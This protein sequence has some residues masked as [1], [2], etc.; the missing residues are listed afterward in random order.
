MA[1]TNQDQQNEHLPSHAVLENH[2]NRVSSSSMS[3]YSRL[4]SATHIG[5]GFIITAAHCLINRVCD[6]PAG[7]G[8]VQLASLNKLGIKYL[9]S[10]DGLTQTAFHDHTAI[11]AIVFHHGFL[12]LKRGYNQP[13]PQ[14]QYD[15]ALIKTNHLSFADAAE[16]PHP[17]ANNF[18]P[19]HISG[20]LYVF[21][22]GQESSEF[23]RHQMSLPG[24]PMQPLP[25]LSSPAQT[26][27]YGKVLATTLKLETL[28]KWRTHEL[29]QATPT[30][31]S[32]AKQHLQ[33]L[34]TSR[35][36]AFSC[37][38]EHA[39]PP[40]FQHTGD[41]FTYP[42]TLYRAINELDK[43]I[44][45]RNQDLLT[46]VSEYEITRLVREQ[47]LNNMIMATS[48]SDGT[49]HSGMIRGVCNGDSGGPLM[50]ESRNIIL[51]VVSFSLHDPVRKQA[52]AHGSRCGGYTFFPS[53]YHHLDWIHSAKTS[54]LAGNH[55]TN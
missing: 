45:Q 46:Q 51:G 50:D 39:Y 19:Q 36:T 22:A 54:V 10:A 1:T 28:I 17:S 11:E 12:G 40:K 7:D 41:G 8:V 53:I 33:P 44:G 30:E 13:D 48:S 21:G 37:V 5:S 25:P 27:F 35:P 52:H 26:Y 49:K 31:A 20:P 6:I 32:H 15:L 42:Q 23:I 2:E 16:L 43:P 24:L 3:A 4:C 29:L 9:S 14:H 38:E 47:S 55:S 34:T 18:S